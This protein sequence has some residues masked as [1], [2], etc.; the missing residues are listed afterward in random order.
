M[1][2][3][4]DDPGAGKKREPLRARLEVRLTDSQLQFLHEAAEADDS[5]SLSDWARRALM[6][7]ARKK[8]ARRGPG[9]G[10]EG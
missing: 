7:M 8:L 9:A 5:G 2:P 4:P 6:K 3:E 1:S 10:D